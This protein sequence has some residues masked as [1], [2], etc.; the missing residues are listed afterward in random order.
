[1]IIEPEIVLENLKEG[2]TQRTQK[3]LDKLNEILEAY[4]NSGQKDFSVTNIGRISSAGGGPG[5]QSLRATR[6]GYYRRLVEAWATKAGTNLKK[7]LAP[8]SRQRDIPAD[9]K[10]LEQLSDLALRS[11]FGQ[12]IA[13]RN[14][15][16]KEVKLLK[17]NSD[18]VI[19]N[20]PVPP[21]DARSQGVQ[22]GV[23]V[24]PALTSIL[25]EMEI[26]ALKY[27]ISDECMEK[28]GWLFT[29]A[30]QVKD[31]TYNNEIFARGFVTAIKK[32]LGEIGD[33]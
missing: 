3:S 17:E 8:F 29:K 28:Q 6:N 11:L 24:V 23:V 16:K 12:I 13:E 4:F 18:K 33:G 26:S 25:C 30:G 9:H 20:R 27:A 22:E 5:Y 15:L 21:S 10:L 7:P 2:K 19:D 14:R 31:S 1:M 32:V